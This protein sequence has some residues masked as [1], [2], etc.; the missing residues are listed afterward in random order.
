MTH[1]PLFSVMSVGV[2]VLSDSVLFFFFSLTL[3]FLKKVLATRVCRE[4]NFVYLHQIVHSLRKEVVSSFLSVF[5]GPARGPFDG[6]ND[7]CRRE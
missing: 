5:Q 2:G 6:K 3:I 4:T 7:Q 1:S